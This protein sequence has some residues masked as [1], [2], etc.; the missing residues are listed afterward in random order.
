MAARGGPPVLLPGCL[1]GGILL[2]W[3]SY[4]GALNAALVYGQHLRAAFDLH[5]TDLL[6]ALGEERR[7][8]PDAERERWMR[9]CLFWHRGVPTDHQIPPDERPRTAPAPADAQTGSSIS[10][11]QLTVA[12]AAAAGLVGALTL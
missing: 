3:A 2:S 7:P 1:W 10:L 9:I 4:R 11:T 12:V 6:E 8:S 5:R